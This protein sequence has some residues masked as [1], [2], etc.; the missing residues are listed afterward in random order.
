MFSQIY[1]VSS[2]NMQTFESVYYVF[3]KTGS[4]VK[5]CTS[6]DNAIDKAVLINKTN[7][8]AEI[9]SLDEFQIDREQ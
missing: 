8:I 9:E 7:A 1:K 6:L 2:I 5:A 4:A 3:K